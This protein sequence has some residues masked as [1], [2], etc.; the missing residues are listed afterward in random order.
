MIV[1][2]IDILIFSHLLVAHFS[3]VLSSLEKAWV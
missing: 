1:Q 2:Q 3:T